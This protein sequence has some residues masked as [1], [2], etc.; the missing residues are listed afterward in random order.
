M[1]Y[2]KT[3]QSFYSRGEKWK[4]NPMLDIY[5]EATINHIGNMISNEF[6]NWAGV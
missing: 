6:L 1:C 5:V 4:S 2:D 3:Y